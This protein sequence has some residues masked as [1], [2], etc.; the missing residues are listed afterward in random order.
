MRIGDLSVAVHFGEVGIG[1][2]DVIREEAVLTDFL[3]FGQEP[4]RRADVDPV[5]QDPGVRGDPDETALGDRTGGPSG[6]RLVTEPLPD[7]LVVDVG[8]PPERDQG[9]YVEQGQ[10]VSPRRGPVEPSPE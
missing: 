1:D 9:V 2:R 3:Q 10:R 6:L 4:S 5:G 7:R 8:I